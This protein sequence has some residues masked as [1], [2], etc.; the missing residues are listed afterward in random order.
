MMLASFFMS[1]SSAKQSF[2]QRL[3]IVAFS[4]LLGRLRVHLFKKVEEKKKVVAV[5]NF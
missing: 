4:V 1:V 2:D 5:V 3:V